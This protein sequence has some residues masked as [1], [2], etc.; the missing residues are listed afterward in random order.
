MSIC[1]RKLALALL[2]MSLLVCGVPRAGVGQTL[3]ADAVVA[4]LPR[5]FV[6]EFRWNI[7]SVT[8]NVAIRFDTVQRLDAQHVEAVGCGTYEA[9]GTVTAIGVKMQITLPGLDVEIRESAPDQPTFVT[10]GSHRG[11]LSTDLRAIDAQ[12]T[13]ASS[14]QQGRLR[15]QAAP[16]ARCAPS[17]ST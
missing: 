4:N 14:G 3:D 7:D 13:T 12:W 16:A 9:A 5:A 8:Q 1:R 6:G 17:R 2:A 15:L 10:D 11:A